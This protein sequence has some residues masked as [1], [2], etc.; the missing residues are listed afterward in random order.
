M[1]KEECLLENEA[2]CHTF[3]DRATMGITAVSPPLNTR[4]IYYLFSL[5]SQPLMMVS[6]QG[7]DGVEPISQ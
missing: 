4:T 1:I 3:Q 7:V 5:G 2:Y 6:K